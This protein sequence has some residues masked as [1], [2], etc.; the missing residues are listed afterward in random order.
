MGRK[1][2]E[3]GGREEARERERGGGRRREKPELVKVEVGGHSTTEHLSW[4]QS[5][6]ESVRWKKKMR[7]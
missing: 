3:E 1:R 6:L 5:K 7:S 4:K 2:K